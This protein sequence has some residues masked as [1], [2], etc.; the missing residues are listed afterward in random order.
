M[1]SKWKL[2]LIFYLLQSGTSG[3][4]Y[5]TYRIHTKKVT[6]FGLIHDICLLKQELNPLKSKCSMTQTY[7]CYEIFESM[8]MILPQFLG[9]S[10]HCIRETVNNSQISV[11]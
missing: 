7:I 3:K 11:D 10:V 8:I 4:K 5:C 9:T 1:D 6:I 2:F